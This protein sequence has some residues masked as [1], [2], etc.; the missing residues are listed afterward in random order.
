MLGKNILKLADFERIVEGKALP[1]LNEECCAN[2]DKNFGFL[3]EHA[4]D[5]VIYGINTGFGPMAQYR[6][7]GGELSTLQYNLIRSHASGNGRSLTKDQC[8]AILLSR[9]QSL[10]QGYSGVPSALLE[11]LKKMLEADVVPVIYEHGGVGASGDLVQLAH[12]A[13]AVIGEGE[14]YHGGEKQAASTVFKALGIAPYKIQLREGLAMING[15]SAMTG[16]GILNVRNAQLLLN[17]ALLLSCMINELVS[18]FDDHFSEELNVVKHHQGQ[19]YIAAQMRAILADSRCITKRHEELSLADKEVFDRKVQEYY[20]L[21]CLPQI[22]G[23]IYDTIEKVGEVLEN[24]LNSVNDNPIVDMDKK[25]IFH[26]GNF[27]GEYVSLEMDKL[28][29]VVTK[30]SMLIERQ[31][32]FLV[33]PHL[34]KIL[35]PFVNH[36]RLGLHLGMQGS[37]FTATSTTAESQTLSYP[38]YLHSIPNNNDNMDIVSMGANA[39]LLCNQVLEN[40]FQVLAVQG[41]CVAQA[42]DFL[43]VK[44]KLST[45]TRHFYEGIRN[46]V[47]LFKEDQIMYDCLRK[48]GDYLKSGSHA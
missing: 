13:L 10:I 4:S 25:E 47:P 22:L 19:Q 17:H 31:I 8:K 3:Q 9:Y 30:L 32:N 39:A 43:Q 24:E 2:L 48:L 27:H 38:M 23:P 15:T 18:S 16:I 40:T 6:V 12:L 36:G 41:L 26:G 37:I 21:R 11:H 33:N 7:S 42:V 34:N 1:E 45:R 28:K 44:E 35:P 46:V 5:K 29:I 20:S 14:V